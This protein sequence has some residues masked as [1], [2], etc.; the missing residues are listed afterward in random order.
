[1]P[2]VATVAGGQTQSVRTVVD[3]DPGQRR[4]VN[5]GGLL[6]NPKTLYVLTVTVGPVNGDPTPADGRQTMALAVAG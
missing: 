6:L 4:A 2:V 3:L 1:V 5:L